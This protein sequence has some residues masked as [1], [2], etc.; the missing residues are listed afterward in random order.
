MPRRTSTQVL[1]STHL[2]NTA[3]ILRESIRILLLHSTYFH[4][5]SIFLFSPLPISLFI[6]HFL[7]HKFPQ[8]PFSLLKLADDLLGQNANFLLPNI[9]SKA[10]DIIICLPSTITFSLLG[11]AAT[12]QAVSDIYSG[13]SLNGTRLFTRSGLVWVKLLHTSFW[14]FIILLGLFGAFFATLATVPKALVFLF[15]MRSGALCFW[16]VLGFVGIP[17]CVAFAHVMVV[18]NLARVVSVLEG[19]CFGFDSILKARSLVRGRLHTA[20]A[21]ALVSNVGL[22]LVGCFFE[23]RMGKGMSLWECPILVSMYSLVLVLDTV[24]NV[25]FYF[26][27]KPCTHSVF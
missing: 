1:E 4:A 10:L 2:M 11:R 15:G 5:I 19:E 20:L 25:I 7:I 23:F 8:T 21:M 3:Q 9:L 6:S 17:F 27:C 13:V 26:T 12:V 22:R 14:E 18:G 24:T 16:G